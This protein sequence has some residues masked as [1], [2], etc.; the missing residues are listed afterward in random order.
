[1]TDITMSAFEKQLHVMRVERD[2][3]LQVCMLAL[4]ALALGDDQG[5]RLEA[6]K[7]L[8]DIC[9]DKVLEARKIQPFDQLWE[10]E[11]QDNG[12]EQQD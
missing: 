7:Q 11:E 12:V 4:R 2:G 5:L 3:L 8:L 6:V 10:K 9:D 1:M